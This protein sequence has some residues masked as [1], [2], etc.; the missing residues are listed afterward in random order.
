MPTRVHTCHLPGCLSACPPRHLF[1]ASH[2]AMV[3]RAI[4]T[5]VYAT[6]KKRG[7]CVDA[8]WAPWWRAQA[9]AT[10]AVLRKTKPEAEAQIAKWFEHEMAVAAKM[11]AQ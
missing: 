2:W 3:P 8:S 11:E 7:R 10:E 1:C 5:R 6:V 4:Q 9:E